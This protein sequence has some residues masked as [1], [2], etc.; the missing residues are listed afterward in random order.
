[1]RNAVTLACTE[2]KQRNYQTNKNKKND[3]DRLEFNKYCKFCKKQ[4]LHK[5]TK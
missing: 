1:M 5:E 4:T 2:C 3:P